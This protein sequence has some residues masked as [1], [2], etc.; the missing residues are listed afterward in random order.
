MAKLAGALCDKCP[1]NACGKA[2]PLEMRGSKTLIVGDIPS[3]SDVDEGRP[4]VDAA[5]IELRQ[6][7]NLHG[8]ARENFNWTLAVACRPPDG[9]LDRIVRIAA[10]DRKKGFDVLSPVEACRPRLLAQLAQHDHVLA[11]GATASKAVLDV[12]TGVFDLRG[13]L[14]AK[15]FGSGE[16]KV[17]VTLHPSHVMKQRR[18]RSVFQADVGKAMRYFRNR[19]EWVEPQ[20]YLRLP[21]ENLRAYLFSDWAKNG[22]T[23]V[24]V[25]TTPDSYDEKD[26]PIFDPLTDHIGIV[27]F[28]QQDGQNAVVIP[29]R[30]KGSQVSLYTQQELTQ[31]WTVIADFLE[32]P[33]YKKVGHNF[34][35]YDR[36]CLVENIWRAIG[37][38]IQIE[39]VEDTLMMHH[40]TASE[41]PHGLGFLAT[42]YTDAPSWKAGHTAVTAET[43]HEWQVY[44]ARDVAINA[45]IYPNLRSIA[46]R[47][48]AFKKLH[49]DLRSLMEIEHGMQEVCAGLHKNGILIDQEKREH[50]AARLTHTAETWKWGTPA[51][52]R[53]SAYGAMQAGGVDPTSFNP[54]HKKAD[55]QAF[56]LDSRDQV[57]KLLFEL[58]DL[59]M[60]NNVRAKDVITAS[61][62]KSTGDE[63]LRSYVTDPRL[64]E[65][66]RD[67]I[68]ALRMYRRNTKLLGTFVHPLRPDFGHSTCRLSPDGKVHADWKA[69]GTAVGRLSADNPNI[70]NVPSDVRDMFIPLPGHSFIDADQ[71]ALHLRII[72][73]RWKIPSLLEAFLGKPRF[74][75]GIRM[76]AHE[77]FAELLFGDTFLDTPHGTWPSENKGE[78]WM[79]PAKAMRDTA[80]T[81]R[82]AGAYGA[83]IQTIYREVTS[84]EDKKTGTLTF[85]KMKL[86]D[87]EDLYDRWMST[88]PEWQKAWEREVQLWKLQGYLADPIHGRRRYFGD[89]KETDVYNYPILALEAA[90][91]NEITL[92]IV[93]AIPFEY[94]GIGTGLVHQNY[95]SVVVMVP[96]NDA[97]RVARIVGEIMSRKLPGMEVPFVGAPVIRKSWA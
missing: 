18:W 88:E 27:G 87:I 63:I 20:M 90:L 11:L 44:N 34:G 6:A 55:M 47:I 7:F 38:R 70:V 95:D 13:S 62:D 19:L 57:G 17:F 74:H 94:L 97:E 54:Q 75:R 9:D 25:E 89:E 30:N 80:K 50:H 41:H 72:A 48:D 12:E 67:F 16:K 24:D 68:F 31:I 66:Q 8:L 5:N 28:C 56:N 64:T 51:G 69:H 35:Y 79:G 39:N 93:K 45:R 85:Q 52:D 36:Q 78:K 23:L 59:P 4:F 61:G 43:D 49:P 22:F 82:Y 29:I 65:F 92:D 84:T 14:Q 1:L 32:D 96:N 83:S 21:P 73:S 3:E 15:D 91:M 76:G 81:V 37:R 77:V 2:V 33:E 71:D 60:P 42:I 46:E 26:N 86:E 10:K 58:W 53:L 40:V